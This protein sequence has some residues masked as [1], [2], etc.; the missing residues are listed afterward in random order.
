MLITRSISSAKAAGGNGVAKPQLTSMVDMLTI[1]LVFLLKSFSMEGNLVTASSDLVLPE[2][3]SMEQPV[4]ELMVEI[5]LGGVKLD[6]ALIAP[7]A[8]FAAADSLMIPGLYSELRTLA[9]DEGLGEE[10]NKVTI[11]CDESL[12]FSIVKRVMFTCAQAS[13]SDFSL[14][15]RRGEG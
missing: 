4:P 2:S 14:L 9:E 13:F 12:D 6:G 3:T 15:V 7:L 8:D 10:E 11:Q 1:L 5:T